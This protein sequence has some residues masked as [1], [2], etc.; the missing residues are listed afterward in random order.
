MS[1][2]ISIFIIIIFI[3]ITCFDTYSVFYVHVSRMVNI[4][5]CDFLQLLYIIKF[6]TVQVRVYFELYPVEKGSN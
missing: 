3:T 6:F 5:I 1:C 2:Y 4:L